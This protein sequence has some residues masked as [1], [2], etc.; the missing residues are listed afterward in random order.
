MVELFQLILNLTTAE[1]FI[2]GSGFFSS[3]CLVQV[4]K[5]MILEWPKRRG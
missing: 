2:L 3:I 4:P 1:T 5:G